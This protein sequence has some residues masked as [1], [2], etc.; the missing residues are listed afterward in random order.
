MKNFIRFLK[1]LTAARWQIRR[2]FPKHS[3]RAIE[4]AVYASEKL[5]MGELRFVVEAGLDWPDL[6]DDISSRERA[7]EVFSHLRV[8]DTEHNSGVLI[9]LL[10]A[11]RKVEIVADRGIDSRVGKTAWISICQDMENQFRTGNFENGVLHGVAAITALL[12][13]HFPAQAHNPNDLPNRPTVL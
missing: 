3:M 8:W 6:L 7:L 1:H 5:H 13:Q 11:D 12:Q 2:L 9:Y 10:L 4:S